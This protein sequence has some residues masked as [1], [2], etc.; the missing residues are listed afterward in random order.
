MQRQMN[1]LQQLIQSLKAE[2]GARQG[3]CGFPAARRQ[4][5]TAVDLGH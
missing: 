2:I 3:L 4:A 5:A 1:Q